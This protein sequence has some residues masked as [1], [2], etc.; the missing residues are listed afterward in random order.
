MREDLNPHGKARTILRRL[1]RHKLKPNV[2]GI[3]GLASGICGMAAILASR[4]VHFVG[5]SSLR[6]KSATRCDDCGTK[7]L[8]GMWLGLC[9]SH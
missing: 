5:M 2:F 8:L 6:H 3:G 9:V 4:V 1:S 7:V